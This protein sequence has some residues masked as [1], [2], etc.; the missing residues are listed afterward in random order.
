MASELEVKRFEKSNLKKDIR[1]LVISYD[2]FYQH[3]YAELY[4]TR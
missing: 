1:Q 2:N 3:L 4:S